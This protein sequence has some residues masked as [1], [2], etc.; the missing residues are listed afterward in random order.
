MSALFHLLNRDLGPA[1]DRLMVL[2]SRPEVIWIFFVLAGGVVV[3]RKGRSG[4]EAVVVALAVVLVVDFACARLLK[5][6]FAHPRPYAA[7][8]GVRVFKGGRFRITKR[9]LSAE[10]YGFP[11]C[12]ATNTAAA[13]VALSLA[14]PL[15]APATG[16][17]TLL[18][19]VSRVY[20]GAHF[21]EDVLFGWAFGGLAG[22][23][24]G[25]LWRRRTTKKG[26]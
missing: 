1:V 11:S 21:P 23:A 12:H 9:P 2:V 25:M 17:F 15:V 4:M 3:L 26:S 10:H 7:L 19:G 5:P 24:G 20:L 14:D 6:F 18:V 22:F 8:S 16:A 13:A